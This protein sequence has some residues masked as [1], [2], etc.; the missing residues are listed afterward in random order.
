[1]SKEKLSCGICGRN[2]EATEDAGFVKF[3]NGES[4]P[5]HLSHPG[6]REEWE[7]QVGSKVE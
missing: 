2:I 7:K 1:M 5:C 4:K 6:V 3:P